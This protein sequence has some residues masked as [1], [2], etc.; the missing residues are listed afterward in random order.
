MSTRLN[1]TTIT[2][3]KTARSWTSLAVKQRPVQM[4]LPSDQLK[5]KPDAPEAIRLHARKPVEAMELREYWT[6]Q[7]QRWA[8]KRHSRIRLQGNKS[9]DAFVFATAILGLLDNMRHDAALR[10]SRDFW[11]VAQLARFMG[12][13]RSN[14]TALAILEHLEKLGAM[15]VVKRHDNRG[16]RKTSERYMRVPK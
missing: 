1:T 15:R 6:P 2:K 13:G 5:A 16:H 14:H 10:G 7:F 8:K 12:L 11:N 9:I 4:A 3:T